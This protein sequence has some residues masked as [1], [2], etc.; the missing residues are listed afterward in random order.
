LIFSIVSRLGDASRLSHHRP[1]LHEQD[2]VVSA[3]TS[4]WFADTHGLKD[5]HLCVSF[6]QQFATSPRGD[7]LVYQGGQS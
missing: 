7:D 4:P 5:I 3:E 6:V 1:C 2:Q